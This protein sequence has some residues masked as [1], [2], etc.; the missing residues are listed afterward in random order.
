MNEMTE[1]VTAVVRRSASSERMSE[2]IKN[3]GQNEKKQ[4]A[5]ERG[6]EL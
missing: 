4:G 1:H 6:A 3:G 5:G 2:R